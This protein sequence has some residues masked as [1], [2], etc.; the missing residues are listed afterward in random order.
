[1]VASP[2]LIGG[3][4]AAL[5]IRERTGCSVVAVERGKQVLVRF[6]HDFAFEA[7]DLVYICGSEEATRK[8]AAEFPAAKSQPA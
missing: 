2:K 4:P 8:F 7:R 3:H 5:R 6:E 1:M